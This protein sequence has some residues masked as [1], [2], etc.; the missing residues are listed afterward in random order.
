M[1]LKIGN[2][3]LENNVILAPMAGV[4]DMPYRILCREQGAGLVCMEMVS[5]K[6][7]LYKN[8]NTQ[9]LLKVDERER[10]VSLQLF[11]SDPD[12]VA[13]IAASLED[14]P[15]DIFDINMGCPVPKIVKNGEGSALMRNPKLVEEILTKL[16]KAVKKPVTVKFRKGFDDTCIN[17][18]EIAKI[19][20]SAGVAAVAVHGRTR[21]QYYS[22]KADWNIIREVKK[23]VKIPVIG[24]G[25]I[26]TAEDALEFI[27]A[28]ATA[29][30]IGTA[31]F[32]NPDT[33]IQVIEGIEAY[34]KKYGVEDIHELIGAVH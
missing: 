33:T 26:M 8:K 20:E 16:V 29:V 7:I 32:I 5:A 30:S 34:M 19:A 14:G 12:I 27:L 18:V 2:V 3:E 23:A 21:E 1:T 10:P 24:M 11:G 9:E 28:G 17:A 22:G 25:G 6:A 15:Y 31:N 13:D 4:T